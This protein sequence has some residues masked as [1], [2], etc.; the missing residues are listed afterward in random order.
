[1]V[2]NAYDAV[3]FFKEAIRT[4]VRKTTKTVDTVAN[5]IGRYITPMI[6]V[7]KKKY[8]PCVTHRISLLKTYYF[9]DHKISRMTITVKVFK[10]FW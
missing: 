10:I 8:V 5:D 6:S 4:K 3:L 9:I 1:M 2:K 7:S